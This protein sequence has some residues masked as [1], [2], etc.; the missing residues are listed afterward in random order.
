MW[1]YYCGN[2]YEEAT[3]EIL[4]LRLELTGSGVFQVA[5]TAFLAR[6]CTSFHPRGR[7]GFGSLIE[8]GT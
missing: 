2:S 3:Q 8:E 5:G 1:N 4:A 7:P 6:R